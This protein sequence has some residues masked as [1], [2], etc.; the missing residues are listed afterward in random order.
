MLTS[1]FVR[2]VNMN[3]LPQLIFR[4]VLYFVLECD[5]ISLM[6]IC[7]TGIANRDEKW[8][9]QYFH[10]NCTYYVE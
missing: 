1:I 5:S 6:N 2:S 3:Q 8:F 10:K 7:V 9:L 4:T